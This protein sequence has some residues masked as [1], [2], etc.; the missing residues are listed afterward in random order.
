[1]QKA[2]TIIR[3]D[4][5]ETPAPKP[6]GTDGYTL[7]QLQEIVGGYI[8]C[9]PSND[10]RTVVLN[11]EGKLKG[12]SPNPKATALVSLFPGDYLVGD[13]LFTTDGV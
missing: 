8:E 4:G 1:M 9:I 5:T 13:V 2:D 7:A 11:E 12:L 6:E 10:G 3:A